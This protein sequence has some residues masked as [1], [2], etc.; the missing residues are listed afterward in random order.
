MPYNQDVNELAQKQAEL[1]NDIQL[2]GEE[3]AKSIAIANNIVGYN[4]SPLVTCL[5]P[6]WE[7]YNIFLK[8]IPRIPATAA[9]AE[10]WQIDSVTNGMSSTY[11]GSLASENTTVRNKKAVPY[12]SI[13]VY[14]YVTYEAQAQGKDFMDPEAT[15]IIRALRKLRQKEEYKIIGGNITA[16]ATPAAPSCAAS[17]GGSISAG[18]YNVKVC[19]LTAECLQSLILNKNQGSLALIPYLDADGAA[20]SGRWWGAGV[21]SGATAVTTTTV[22][23]TVTVTITPT[24]NAFA[25]AVFMQTGADAY[26]LQMIS[27]Y[28]VA[29]L[30]N[31]Y[32]SGNAIPS[33]E[34]SNDSISFDGLLPQ[35]LAAGNTFGQDL[36]Y[37]Y[38]TAD[39]TGVVEINDALA[40]IFDAY[41]IAATNIYVSGD[42]RNVITKANIK[43]GA[44]YNLVDTPELDKMTVGRVAGKY[45]HPSIGAPIDIETHPYLPKGTCMIMTEQV[46][47]PELEGTLMEMHVC[48]DYFQR[49][50]PTSKRR[51]AFEIFAN[52]AL[53]MRTPQYCA[54]LKNVKPGLSA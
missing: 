40:G 49:A 6:M 13:G 8:K 7:Q 2:K 43:K 53:G 5:E 28:S 11:E 17:S 42:L 46:P 3:V 44:V 47:M 31:Y 14:D 34:G 37:N 23:K 48:Q 35:I 27:T 50:V 15:S 26:T 25:Y 52:E 30:T 16:L 19:P 36:A 51:K 33:V 29:T 24:A 20:I 21:P 38:F 22:N 1:I 12:K 10:W 41:R 45:L 9:Q 39:E 18:T 54:V 4:L 32:T